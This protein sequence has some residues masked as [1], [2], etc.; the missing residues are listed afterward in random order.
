MSPI[1][2]NDLF[3]MIHN[4]R[5]ERGGVQVPRTSSEKY[6]GR[7]PIRFG[8]ENPAHYIS[9]GLKYAGFTHLL[10]RR[11]TVYNFQKGQGF[12]TPVC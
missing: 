10:Y 4:L 5:N 9:S 2:I 7:K 3:G 6:T 12:L 1:Y 11:S 8:K